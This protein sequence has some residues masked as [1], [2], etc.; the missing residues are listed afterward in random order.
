MILAGLSFTVALLVAPG[1]AL[2]VGLVLFVAGLLSHHV[3]SR[4]R[5]RHA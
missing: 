5:G 3:V 2:F 1:S 4:L